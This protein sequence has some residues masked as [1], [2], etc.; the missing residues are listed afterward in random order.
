MA[1]KDDLTPE[2]LPRQDEPPKPDSDE[3]Q[4]PEFSMTEEEARRAMEFLREE[5]NLIMGAVAGL[6]AAVSGAVIWA[7]ITVTTDYQSGWMAV[8]IG[9][10]VGIAV[11]TAG[12][13][14]DQVFGV[15]GATMSLLG[16][17]LGNIF[18]FAYVLSMQTGSPLAEV[19]NQLDIELI[20]EFMLTT[21]Q[22]TD[23]LFYG[24]AVYFGYRYAF[25]QLTMDDFNRALGRAM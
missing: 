16:C 20:A 7:I 9:F 12:K 10:L 2:N 19:L 4:Q 18:T 11:R 14:I 22:V 17:A 24:L 25:R 15:I 6:I 3:A 21:F 8:G 5:Q 1:R 13:G 23:I